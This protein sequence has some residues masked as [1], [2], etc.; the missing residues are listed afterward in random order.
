MMRFRNH[1]ASC[2]LALT[3]AIIGPLPVGAAEKTVAAVNYALAY[4]TERLV[5]GDASVTFPVPEG[6]DPEFWR[7]TISDVA[8]LQKA[9]LIV[10]NGAGFAGWTAKVSLP[11]SKIVVAG[12]G[13]ESEFI[14]TEAV[15][16][17]HGGGEEHSHEG[18]ASYL[19]LDPKLAA[20]QAAN[21][22]AG[23][24]RRRI[25]D[26]ATID[27]RLADLSNDLEK[28]EQQAHALGEAEQSPPMI[29][30]HPRYQYLAKAFGWTI[31]ALDLEA[32]AAPTAEQLKKLTELK[33]ETGAKVLL[34][35]KSVSAA[36]R[37]SVQNLG[38][39]DSVFPSLASRPEEKDFLA[40]YENALSALKA[41]LNQTIDE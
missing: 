8:A 27:S 9:D 32:G 30:T 25:G 37:E 24:K 28:L 4:M 17:S 33:D 3:L 29:A 41:A 23:L 15:T 40:A 20:K 10:L 38:F 39:A 11:R 35:E 1:V 26:P 34:W 6:V 36:A 22:A 19:W 7:P 5:G 21:I 31:Y 12:K 2:A 18:T 13:L 14:A 16:H